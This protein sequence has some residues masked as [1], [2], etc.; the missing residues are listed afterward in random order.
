M[1]GTYMHFDNLKPI[2]PRNLN[3]SKNNRKNK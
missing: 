1:L 3:I 2:E